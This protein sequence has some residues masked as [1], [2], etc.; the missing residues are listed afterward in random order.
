MALQVWRKIVWAEP[1]AT[2]AA[3]VQLRF[4]QLRLCSVRRCCKKSLGLTPASTERLRLH[5]NYQ[6]RKEAGQCH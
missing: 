5:C 6:L 2:S 1:W 3:S 4:P